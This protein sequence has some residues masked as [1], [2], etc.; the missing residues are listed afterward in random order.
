MG[1]VTKVYF[2]SI[3]LLTTLLVGLS[4]LY[5][6]VHYPTDVLAGWAGGRVALVKRLYASGSLAP[7]PRCCGAAGAGRFR[8][9][10]FL[11]VHDND[12]ETGQVVLDAEAYRILNMSKMLL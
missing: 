10:R 6:G 2:L 3:A 11:T 1:D 8:R 5:L 9:G 4:R 12:W 7:A